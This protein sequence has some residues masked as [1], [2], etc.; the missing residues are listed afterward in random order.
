MCKKTCGLLVLLSAIGLHLAPSIC[1]ALPEH[2]K[3]L[4]KIPRC[5]TRLSESK[6]P[7]YVGDEISLLGNPLGLSRSALI[8]ILSDFSDTPQI[9][10]DRW[11]LPLYLSLKTKRL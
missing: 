4:L 10:N 8:Y 2:P 5:S 11:P 6:A 1:F 9:W 7:Y 3:L